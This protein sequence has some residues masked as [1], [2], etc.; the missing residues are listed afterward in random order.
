MELIP[1]NEI[2]KMLLAACKQKNPKARQIKFP[3]Y[4]ALC[5]DVKAKALEL[6]LLCHATDN[7][8]TD[9]AAFEAWVLAL[10]YWI[11]DFH[12]YT[13]RLTWHRPAD[14]NDGH[15]QRF[16]YRAYKFRE[17]FPKWFCLVDQTFLSDSK[18]SYISGSRSK[19]SYVLNYPGGPA[20]E[21]AQNEE[22]RLERILLDQAQFKDIFK[23][24]KKGQQLP[25]GVFVNKITKLNAVFTHGHSDID[26][27][28]QQQNNVLNIFELKKF[29]NN[30]IGI[31][32]EL[33]FYT[34]LMDDLRAGRVG[35]LDGTIPQGRSIP[36]PIYPKAAIC[37]WFLAP[38]LH[39]LINQ[40]LIATIN[41]A[42][43]NRNI[44]FKH[45]R[46]NYT[47]ATTGEITISKIESPW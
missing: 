10:K 4:L 26:L 32:S 43:A 23:F 12:D 21:T 40:E 11:Q 45:M 3:L 37:S 16:L 25:V 39:P 41:S 44:E 42:L 35:Y 46:F 15:Y 6:N 1:N 31:I 7:M 20:S 30:K 38:E 33:F 8:Q 28:G 34:M 2:A 27:W 13:V 22:A 17:L 36:Y 18:L 5:K 19:D 9:T 14:I 47:K 29:K 24:S